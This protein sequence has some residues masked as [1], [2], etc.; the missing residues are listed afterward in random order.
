ML[1]AEL[2]D[3]LWHQAGLLPG[4]IVLLYSW[5]PPRFCRFQQMGIW[6]QLPPL[7]VCLWL[8]L[9][10]ALPRSSP[11]H[12]CV[13]HTTSIFRCHVLASSDTLFP[14]TYK[15]ELVSIKMRQMAQLTF[16]LNRQEI[17]CLLFS[18][19]IIALNIQNYKDFIHCLFCFW[20]KIKVHIH[21]VNC[22]MAI[23][24][25]D[26]AFFWIFHG[27]W[28]WASLILVF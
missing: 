17:L 23:R 13:S 5:G 27:K 2:S 10:T 9:C 3:L 16:H 18:K 4:S 19:A 25:G 1:A 15:R 11:L 7:L 20:E 6:R 14:N 26:M 24:G 12:L 8:V 21:T 22:S 28:S